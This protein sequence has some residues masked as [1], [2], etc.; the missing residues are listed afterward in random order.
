MKRLTFKERIQNGNTIAL[1]IGIILAT[2]ILLTNTKS[3]FGDFGTYVLLMALIYAL[4]GLSVNIIT[5]YCGQL[6]LGQAGFFAVGA[7]AA[8]I[9]SKS[10]LNSGLPHFVIIILGI[11]IGA[12][13]A[14]VFGFLIG[15]PTLRLSGDYLAIV[16]LGFAE[17]IRILAK[18]LEWLTG[19]GIGLSGIPKFSTS[20][21][22]GTFITFFW[23]LSSFLIVVFFLMMFISAGSG[24][25]VVAV[26]EDEIAANAMGINIKQSKQNAF[27]LAAVVAGIGGALFTFT[28]GS[29]NPTT[30]QFQLSV[31]FLI[32]AVFGGL[33]SL[34]GTIIAGVALTV[35]NQG[36]LPSLKGLH[37]LLVN[38]QD[39]RL[40]I[41]ALIL[42]VVMVYQPKGLLGTKELS[43]TNF[44][45]TLFGNKEIGRIDDDITAF[46]S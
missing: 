37:P 46:K 45:S 32:I 33:G 14:G 40:P 9:F 17:I 23:V 29:I 20:R 30:F 11:L 4:G 19:G 13:V 8:G 2:L 27:I 38:I 26:R 42:I 36:I 43:V 12:I 44:W 28:Q 31:D 16:T 21:F 24:R 10:V 34:S 35:I 5:G 41:Y 39:W 22:D 15:I 1:T 6:S 25:R 18:N 7:Y 3:L